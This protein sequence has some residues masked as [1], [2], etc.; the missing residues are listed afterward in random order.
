M[1]Q[2]QTQSFVGVQKA[3]RKGRGLQT[4]L[5]ASALLVLMV[6][7]VGI[8]EYVGVDPAPS[9]GNIVI[10]NLPPTTTTEIDEKIWASQGDTVSGKYLASRHAERM[11]NFGVAADLLLDV[12][13]SQPDNS[14]LAVRAHVLLV[15]EGRFDE[16]QELAAR[17]LEDNDTN[18]F[19]NLTIAMKLVEEEAYEEALSHI[20]A[21]PHQGANTLLMPML[22]AWT[23]AGMGEA[24]AAYESVA[25]LNR[26]NAFDTLKGL[27]AGV[28]ADMLG[29]MLRAEE[30]YALALGDGNDLPLR[31]AEIYVS[32]LTRQERWDEAEVFLG[33]YSEQN[34]NS[35][36]GGPM[37]S[38]M[39]AREKMPLP[40]PDVKSGYAEAFYSIA[41]LLNTGQGD[42]QPLLFVRHALRL[43]PDDARS[44][45]LLG[46][47]LSVQERDAAAIAAFNSIATSSP[48]SW[49]AR[50]SVA[51]MLA[52][53]EGRLDEA[54]SMLEAMVDERPLRFDAARA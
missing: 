24:D 14:G 3:K 5:I 42:I 9:P 12:L 15:S 22:E 4:V 7:A 27:H 13:E 33:K 34:P 38:A 46:D 10:G 1:T 17:V 45:F 43:L 52:E 41:N 48:F 6:L 25:Q 49:Y 11:S 18:A 23:F 37:V 47:I 54:V 28:L 44:L 8:R 19:A 29:D 2:D 39:E 53:Q 30:E 16:A 32:F 35:L 21:V 26:N 51:S 50:L 36:L 31:V 20:L 40:V